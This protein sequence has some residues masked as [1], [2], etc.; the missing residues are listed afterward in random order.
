MFGTLLLEEQR[1]VTVL[2]DSNLYATL[3]GCSVSALVWHEQYLNQLCGRKLEGGCQE[4][5]RRGT[6][7]CQERGWMLGMALLFKALTVLF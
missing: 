4:L 1:T 3:T 5:Y 7:G 6:A 2:Q